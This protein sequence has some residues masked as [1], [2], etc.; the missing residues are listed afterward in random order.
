MSSGRPLLSIGN[1]L[2]DEDLLEAGQADDVARAGVLN[3]DRSKTLMS[4]QRSDIGAFTT[5]IRG[6][7]RTTESPTLTRPLTMR[8][9]ANRPR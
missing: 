3:L 8:P 1:C 6:E 7:C 9:K 2:S 5:A 4:K